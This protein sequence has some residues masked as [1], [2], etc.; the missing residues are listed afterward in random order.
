M[1][2]ANSYTKNVVI[3][4]GNQALIGESSID[5]K[6]NEARVLWTQSDM[7]EGT[8]ALICWRY[9]CGLLV[10]TICHGQAIRTRNPVKHL[11]CDKIES[12]APGL[13]ALSV[14]IG[15]CIEPATNLERARQTA[16]RRF[17]VQP[18]AQFMNGEIAVGRT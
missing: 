17:L 7:C 5:I 11:I 16:G 3:P 13:R 14:W 2:V 6:V 12:V 9:R 4:A 1:P 18:E 8:Q 15:C 10:F